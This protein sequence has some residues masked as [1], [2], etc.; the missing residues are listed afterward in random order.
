MA[1]KTVAKFFEFNGAKVPS[2]GLG[3]A[4]MTSDIS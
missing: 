2:V 1:S 3:T 4:F